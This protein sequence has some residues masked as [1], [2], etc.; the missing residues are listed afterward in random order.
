MSGVDPA[1]QRDE[2]KAWLTKAD[3]DLAAVRVCL[4]AR[5]ALLGVAAYH[6]QQ[7]A[8]KLIKGLLVLAAIPFRKTHD[9]DELSA[10]A[11]PIYP[12]LE[13]LFAHLRVRTYWGF[14][15]RYPM[16]AGAG[17][18]G[19]RRDRAD[20]SPPCGS[21]RPPRHVGGRRPR[22]DPAEE[23]R[24]GHFQQG[25]DQPHARSAARWAGAVRRARAEGEARGE[26]AEG[27]QRQPA[28]GSAPA[29][30]RQRRL[31]H[32][33]PVHGHGQVVGR[34]VPLPARAHGA[35]AT[36][37]SCARPATTSR[38]RRPSPTTTPSAR[39][40]RRSVC[41]ARSPPASRRRRSSGCGS[42][43]GARSTTSSAASRCAA[44][45]R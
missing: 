16:P 6:C 34:R 32:P 28:R 39:W 22:L 38:T 17:A 2:A 23:S 44:R 15:F 25:P 8:E 35:L 27:G 11:A 3:E 42:S 37:T 19:S 14:A 12:D 24:H 21:A 18:T 10:A 7:A 45:P 26:L 20:A 30:R 9:L 1:K 41:C 4:D 29:R 33:G 5:P 40:I 31:G 13:P 43:S 36:S